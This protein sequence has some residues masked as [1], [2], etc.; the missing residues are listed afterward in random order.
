[1]GKTNTKWVETESICFDLKKFKCQKG[2]AQ[3][4]IAIE[5]IN[6]AE[7]KIHMIVHK[8]DLKK[9]MGIA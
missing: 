5:G 1:M 8:S 2:L 6:H 4:E 7:E 3:D 9:I